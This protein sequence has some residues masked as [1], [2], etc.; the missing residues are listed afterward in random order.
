MTYRPPSRC[1]LKQ[2]FPFLLFAAALSLS[3]CGG[4]VDFNVATEATVS[5][6]VVLD[7]AQ[8]TTDRLKQAKLVTD[9]ESERLDKHLRAAQDGTRAVGGEVRRGVAGEEPDTEKY[10]ANMVKVFRDTFDKVETFKLTVLSLTN[11]DARES[12]QGVLSMMDD[13][14][15]KVA[16]AL[17]CKKVNLNCVR[18]SAEHLDCKK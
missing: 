6:P 8:R 3:S 5:L 1:K 11:A 15:G 7:E 18:C 16:T 4:N 17:G 12:Y 13:D 9:E 14:L 10:R 2:T